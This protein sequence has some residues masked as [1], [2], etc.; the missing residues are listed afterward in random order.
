MIT[1]RILKTVSIYLSDCAA[2]NGFTFH[3]TEELFESLIYLSIYYSEREVTTPQTSK[4][5]S[6]AKKVFS[7]C[8]L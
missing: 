3:L 1:K 7:N 8:S 6:F 2:A 5:K 4:I